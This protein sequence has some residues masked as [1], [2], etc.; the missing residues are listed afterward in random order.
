PSSAL[1]KD[2]A[3]VE[4]EGFLELGTRAGRGLRVLEL[5]EVEL[6]RDALLLHAV[7]LRRQPAP[8]VGLGEDELRALE[9]AIVVPELLHR[10]DDDALD[11][12]GLHRRDRA[13]RR[14]QANFRHRSTPS[15]YPRAPSR[16]S[17]EWRSCSPRAPRPRSL[18]MPWH[19]PGRASLSACYRPRGSPRGNRGMRSS[20]RAP[21]SCTSSSR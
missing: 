21:P 1:A 4:A 14:R 17:R 6:E 8:L 12:L 9:R 18:P 5:L 7:E 3:E 16:R 10:L 2:F 20:D 15:G 11:L 19:L 13:E